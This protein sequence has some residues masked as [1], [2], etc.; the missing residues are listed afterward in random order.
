MQWALPLMLGL[1]AIDVLLSGRDLSQVYAELAGAVG[2]GRHPIMP[3]LQRMV[4]LLLVLICGDRIIRHFGEGMRV[5]SM[6]LMG[7]YIAYWVGTVAFPSVFGAHPQISHEYT[8]ALIIGVAVLLVT[9]QDIAAIV[10]RARDALF[11]LMLVSVLLVVVNPAMVLDASY[12]QGLLPGVPRLG[13]VAPHPV[14]MGMFAQTGL[15]LLWARPYQR[16]WMTLLAWTIGLGC[17]FFAQSKTAWIAFMLCAIAMFLVRSGSNVWQR[18]SDPREGAF[19]IV[20]CLGVMFVGAAIMA[21]LMFGNVEGQ[22]S[23]FLDSS[24][25]AQLMSLTGRDQIWAIAIEEWQANKFFGYGPGLWDDDFRQSIGMPNA[26]NAHNQFMD[27]LA[28][29]GTI[30]AI[31][32]VIYAAV[33]LVLSFKYARRSGGLSVALFIALALRSVSEVPLLLFGYGTELFVHMLLLLVLAAAA[34]VP[35]PIR[36]ARPRHVYGMPA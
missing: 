21:L 31:A 4:S 36:H 15:I 17:L 3:W 12:R 28:R 10:D 8:Y 27:T 13:G 11:M 34:S 9:T 35:V 22:V 5:P 33:L 29:T 19:G 2:G 18:A 1:V 6:V 20:L 7:A 30:G 25:G 14:A 24:Q 23:G 32:L 16:R 26:T